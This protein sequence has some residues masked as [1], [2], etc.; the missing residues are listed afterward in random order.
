MTETKQVPTPVQVDDLCMAYDEARMKVEEARRD[1]SEA[2]AALLAAIQAHGYV[3]KGAEKTLRLDGQVYVADATTATSI[4]IMDTA[5]AELQAELSRAQKPKVFPK[6]F[7]RRVRYLLRKGAAD[8]LRL[9][10]GALSDD[11]QAHLLGLFSRC[12][13]AESK[14]PS[15]SVQLCAVL[16]KKE[17]D[18]AARAEKKARGK[19]GG[20]K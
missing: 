2:K 16:Q 5:V 3:P 20:A 11:R 8:I 6:L 15:V 4:E 12:F 10:I 18:A 7:E 13:I 9:A 14:A 1:E 17:A 19:K